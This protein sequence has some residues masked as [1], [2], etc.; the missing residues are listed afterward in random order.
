MESLGTPCVAKAE[1]VAKALVVVLSEK[2]KTPG[3]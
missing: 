1:V 3:L 2:K